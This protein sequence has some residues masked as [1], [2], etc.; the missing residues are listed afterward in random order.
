[1]D[2]KICRYG[3][4]RIGEVVNDLIFD[5]TVLVNQLAAEA[6]AQ[7]DPL[8]AAL[9]ALLKTAPDARRTGEHHRLQD[10]AL[11]APVARPGKIIAAPVNYR[12]H[13]AEAEA[14]PGV[15]YGHTITDIKDA[16]LF[17]KAPSALA[18]P[19]DPLVIRFPERRTDYELELVALIGTRG[20]DISES[21]ALNHIAGYA[22]GL[23]ITLRGPEDR[24]FRKSID[25]YAIIGPWLTTADEITNPDMLVLLLEQNGDVRQS[26]NTSQMVYGMAQLISF[27]SS[28]YTLEVGD[29]LFTGTP[30]G[31]GPIASGDRLR[32]SIDGLGAMT[33]C[34]S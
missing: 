5:I 31:V 22:V 12:N 33:I 16:G 9:P 6:P 30:E 27:A 19:C 25:G 23:D 17:L 34:V 14:D 26:A 10:T 2:V 21:E 15:R 20:S 13:I 8:L 32:A 18:G 7:D 4:D 11:H 1:M 28:F 3:A 29:V 24:S